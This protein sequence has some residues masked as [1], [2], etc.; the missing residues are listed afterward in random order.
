MIHHIQR[1]CVT[2]A[3][4]NKEQ[5]NSSGLS[6]E[7]QGTDDHLLPTPGAAIYPQPVLHQLQARP[8]EVRPYEEYCTPDAA[9]ETLIQISHPSPAGCTQ[10][11]SMLENVAL[12]NSEPAA[13]KKK[14]GREEDPLQLEPQTTA[15]KSRFSGRLFIPGKLKIVHRCHR[16]PE[17]GARGN[18]RQLPIIG[19][20]CHIASQ[21]DLSGL[22]TK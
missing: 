4:R 3:P 6:G 17:T 15:T 12:R 22:S 21:G 8:S 9:D 5:E 10:L 1:A 19:L 2:N 13:P 16:M 20:S 18:E 11:A 14:L 7:F